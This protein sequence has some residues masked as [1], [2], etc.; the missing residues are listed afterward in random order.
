MKSP[1]VPPASQREFLMLPYWG[2]L[3]L[4]LAMA[5]AV[6]IGLSVGVTVLDTVHEVRVRTEQSIIESNLNA[7]KIAAALSDG[8]IERQRALLAAA[9]AWSDRRE[10][11]E[12][13]P[14]DVIASGK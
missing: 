7:D 12:E 14:A 1:L 5:G 10:P 13:R 4:R 2:S 6:L 8:V 9:Q 3:K 11:R